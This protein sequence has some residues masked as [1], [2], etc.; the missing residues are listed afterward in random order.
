MSRLSEHARAH[1]QELDRIIGPENKAEFIRI[2]RAIVA[3]LGD[4]PQSR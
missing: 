2:L 1:D 3:G 4:P